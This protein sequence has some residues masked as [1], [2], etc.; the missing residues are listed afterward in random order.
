[1][2]LASPVARISI[3]MSFAYAVALM[4]GFTVSAPSAQGQTFTVL[5]SFKGGPDGNS[6]LAGVIR[7]AAGNL[8]S[9]TVVG[10]NLSCGGSGVGCGTVFKLDA[11]GKQTVLHRFTD[12]ADG[13]NPM[14]GGV[15]QDAAGNLYGTTFNGADLNGCI[16]PHRREK[17]Q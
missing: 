14:E 6:P 3:S 11:T 17:E 8:Y 10:G 1:M 13:A 2:R 16:A 9:T 15:I 4:A 7:D 12:G 5:Y